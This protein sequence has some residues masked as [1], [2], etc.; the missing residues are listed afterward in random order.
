MNCLIKSD[1]IYC[2]RKGHRAPPTKLYFVFYKPKTNEISSAKQKLEMN[3][4]IMSYENEFMNC[5]L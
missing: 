2:S 5:E 1:G 3:S 4:G